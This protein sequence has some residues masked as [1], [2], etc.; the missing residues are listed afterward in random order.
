MARDTIFIGHATPEDNDFT[1]WLQSKLINEGYQCEC[2][3][4]FLTGG[5]ADYWQNLQDLLSNRTFKYVLVV[6][7]TTFEKQ[8]VLD[9]WEYCKSIE[10]QHNLHDFI[11]PVKIDDTP[12]NTRIGLNRRNIISF[13]EF[14]GSGLKRL[15]RKL[16]KDSTP[17]GDP[18]ALSLENWYSNVYTNWSGLEEQKDVFYSNWLKIDSLPPKIFFYKF[19]NEE[20]AQAI[21]KNNLVYPGFRHGNI[22]VTF[23]TSLN[24]YLGNENLEIEPTEVII[25][26]TEAAFHKYEGDEFP[27]YHDLRR[28]L[29]RLLRDCFTAYLNGKDLLKYELANSNFCYSFPY[30]EQK[31]VKG[32]FTVNGKTKNIGVN[33]VYYDSY[34]HYAISFKPLLYPELSFSIKNHL[35]F[36]EA[37]NKVWTDKKQMHSA[38]RDKGK[39]MRNKEWRDQFLAFM[40]C[41]KTNDGKIE[42]PVS[43]SDSLSINT[44]PILF[45]AN[46]SYIEPNDE[47]R[48]TSIDEYLEEE[49][50]YSEDDE[51]V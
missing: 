29:V 14:W 46:F 45:N 51:N 49:E 48:L 28:L 3:L 1:L 6:S 21:V 19:I 25:K 36:S 37:G 13:E 5:E 47:A 2:D 10:R 7:K 35:V 44:T 34:W 26:E 50:Y 27:V 4:S 40:S 12:Y 33:G 23:Q 16:E 24:Y 41:L 39:T 15:L 20:Q 8:G 9:E 22:I 38:R 30:D 32:Q 31:K 42:I 11:I 17:K 43:E 18:S